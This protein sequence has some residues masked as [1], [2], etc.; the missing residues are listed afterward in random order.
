MRK[1]YL[2][3][4]LIMI[5]ALIIPINAKA[6]TGSVDVSCS[7]TTVPV[8]GTDATVCT[9]KASVEGGIGGAS[10]DIASSGSISIDSINKDSAWSGQINNGKLAVHNDSPVNSLSTIATVN[11]KASSGASVGSTGEVTLTNIELTDSEGNAVNVEDKSISLTI[12]DASSSISSDSTQ[13]SSNSSNPKTMD[14]NVII[15][16]IIVALA[17]CVV[18][19]GKKK[20]DKIS[21]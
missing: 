1:K 3:L 19:V 17:T 15:I 9:I 2:C 12:G 18:I 6:A 11:V 10:M 14:T 21:K 5:T 13:N 4:L 8:S 16:T 20:L 7:P